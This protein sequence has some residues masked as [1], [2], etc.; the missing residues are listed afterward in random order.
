MNLKSRRFSP[1]TVI[2]VF[3]LVLALGGTAVAAKRYLIT[4]TKQI[5]PKALKELATMA[6]SQGAVGAP[7]PRGE[8]GLPGDKGPPGD[9][10]PPGEGGTGGGS[11]SAIRWAV[12]DPDG[13]V[14]RSGGGIVTATEDSTGTYTVIFN[15]D[16]TEC[17]YEATIGLSG[18]TASAFPGFAT[19]VGRA[20]EPKGVFVQ[21]FNSAGTLAEKGFHLAVF[22]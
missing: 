10:G 12:I 20:E 7:G 3:A 14:S 13:T 22:C 8:K 5:S 15:A 9:Q 6:A 2:A 19:V 16:V 1:G 11:G 18:T 17:A 21:T 4:T